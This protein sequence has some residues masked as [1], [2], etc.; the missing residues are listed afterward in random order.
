MSA[1]AF[2]SDWA[3]L[4]AGTCG[5]GNLPFRDP[6]NHERRFIPLRLD[7]A[8]IKGCPVAIPLHQ[9]APGGPRAE[10]CEWLETQISS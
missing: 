7:D 5:R 10:I 6:L 9:L 8:P 4:E 3:Q 2:G 1:Q